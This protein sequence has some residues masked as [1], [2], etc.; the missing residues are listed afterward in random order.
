MP[1]SFGPES[2]CGFRREALVTAR[3]WPAASAALLQWALPLLSAEVSEGLTKQFQA[4]RGSQ[5]GYTGSAVTAHTPT[6]ALTLDWRYGGLEQLLCC[7]F[8]YM[9]KRV[10][11]NTIVLPELLA[12]G[13]YRHLYELD[14]SVTTANLWGA[15]DGV[16][17]GDSLPAGLRKVRRGTVALSR[18]VS[19]WELLSGV[20]DQVSFA[21]QADGKATCAVNGIAYSLSRTSSANTLAVMAALPPLAYPTVLGTDLRVRLAPYSASTPLD[22]GDEVAV[23]AWSLTMQ[24]NLAVQQS[25]EQPLHAAE[26]EQQGTPLVSGS[27]TLPRYQSD[28]FFAAYSANDTYMLE[29]TFTGPLIPHTAT[30][31][32]YTFY[33]PHVKL[34]QVTAPLNQG[35]ANQP[36]LW[37]AQVPIAQAAGFPASHHI[38]PVMLEHVTHEGGH[39]LLVT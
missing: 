12:A 17:G 4:T 29:C 25:H 21:V 6:I 23:T 27:L 33:V 11:G 38:G 16:L 32:A 5:Y 30:A 20:V 7:A 18:G 37:Y 28:T 39:P 15:A 34:T 10:A 36:L 9:A 8:G 26:L 1:L 22:S 19:V 24:H 14:V 35:T 31:Y 13:V 2:Q 3:T